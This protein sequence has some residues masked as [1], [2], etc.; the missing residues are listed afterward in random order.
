MHVALTLLIPPFG[1][2]NANK[3][4]SPDVCICTSMHARTQ[5]RMPKHMCIFTDRNV[6]IYRQKHTCGR[7]CSLTHTNAC[8]C[9]RRHTHRYARTY[10]HVY[11]HTL[12]CMHLPKYARSS[13]DPDAYARPIM[14]RE[15]RRV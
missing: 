14:F 4:C 13:V 9:I 2:L 15:S 12:A 8:T 5:I 7:A 6:H 11:T 1:F 10:A 3:I